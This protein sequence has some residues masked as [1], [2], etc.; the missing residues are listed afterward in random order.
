M[1]EL[2]IAHSIVQLA[3]ETAEQNNLK[4]IDALH[5]KIGVLSGVV[6]EALEFSFDIAT[7]GTSIE[8]AQLIIDEIPLKV[9]C[10]QCENEHVLPKPTPIKCP[11]CNISTGEILEGR[12]IE[13]DSIVGG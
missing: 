4:K 2:S 3:I 8:G 11:K 1:H 12:E 6:K 10:S 5:V 7:E 13:L 9:F